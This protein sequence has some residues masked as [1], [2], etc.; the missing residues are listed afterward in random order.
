MNSSSP[1]W[2]VGGLFAGILCFGCN[3]APADRPAASAPAAPP[4]ATPQGA[5]PAPPAASARKPDGVDVEVVPGGNVDVD[6]QGEPIRDRL[7]E[8]RALR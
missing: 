8:R 3:Q 4:A 7:R 2:F 5:D 6:V 1:C